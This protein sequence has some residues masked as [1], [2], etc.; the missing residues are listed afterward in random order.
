[1][2]DIKFPPFGESGFDPLIAWIYDGETGDLIGRIIFD[3]DLPDDE[4]IVISWDS[5]GIVTFTPP[6]TPPSGGNGDKTDV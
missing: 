4:R 5:S 1:M 3:D 6:N 2:N